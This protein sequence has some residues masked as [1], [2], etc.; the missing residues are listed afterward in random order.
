M[1]ARHSDQEENHYSAYKD[2]DPP[3]AVSTP[4][5]Y[6][7]QP[8]ISS[9]DSPSDQA[10]GNRSESSPLHQKGKSGKSLIFPSSIE[11]SNS[12]SNWKDGIQDRSVLDD[13]QNR[14]V[15]SFGNV[16]LAG[17]GQT[18]SKKSGSLNNQNSGSTPTTCCC[19]NFPCVKDSY[20]SMVPEICNILMLVFTFKHVNHYRGPYLSFAFVVLSTLSSLTIGVSVILMESHEI[21]LY[22]QFDEMQALR[23]CHFVV[24]LLY[25][26]L[27][28]GIWQSVTSSFL[29][30]MIFTEITIMFVMELFSLLATVLKFKKAETPQVE[31]QPI[32]LHVKTDSNQTTDLK[33]SGREQLFLFKKQYSCSCVPCF[34]R[35]LSVVDIFKIGFAWV[36]VCLHCAMASY[37][38]KTHENCTVVLILTLPVSLFILCW[39]RNIRLYVIFCSLLYVGDVYLLMY[40]ISSK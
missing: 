32:Q 34:T 24:M 25:Y 37:I 21:P 23:A 5:R 28:G 29:A 20:L 12:G 6:S 33:N 10:A 9:T 17:D 19:F 16:E 13:T 39:F 15:E 22:A 38:N 30:N 2:K 36:F 3:T 1:G 8:Q 40:C 11:L 18:I 35:P 4:T 26:I 31:K 27:L 7:P 14:D